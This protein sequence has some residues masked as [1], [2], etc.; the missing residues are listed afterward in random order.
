MSSSQEWRS[1]LQKCEDC[2]YYVHKDTCLLKSLVCRNCTF[3]IGVVVPY[4][5]QQKKSYCSF[6][7]KLHW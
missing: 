2:E 4:E 5:V 3:S 6:C 7:L 1:D